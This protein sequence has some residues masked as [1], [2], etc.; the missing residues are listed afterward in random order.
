MG[1][2]GFGVSFDTS[3]RLVLNEMRCAIRSARRTGFGTHQP[4]VPWLPPAGTRAADPLRPRNESPTACAWGAAAGV[5]WDVTTRADDIYP[6]WRGHLTAELDANDARAPSR[7]SVPCRSFDMPSLSAIPGVR[8]RSCVLYLTS[9]STRM[10]FSL[11]PFASECVTADSTRIYL[12]FTA[13]PEPSTYALLALGSGWVIATLRR[14]R[15][16]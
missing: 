9:S 10:A 2:I 16:A 1:L 7:K 12:T 15:R 8:S 11:A 5:W 4:E 3:N 14:R 6:P 13:V